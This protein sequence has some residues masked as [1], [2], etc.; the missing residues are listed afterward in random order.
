MNTPQKL[1]FGRRLLNLISLTIQHIAITIACG[2]CL[3]LVCIWFARLS[4]WLELVVHFSAHALFASF[5]VIPILWVTKHRRTAFVCSLVA[6]YFIFLVQ[7]WYLIPLP[8]SPKPD[9]LR[10]LSWNV[11]KA[12]EEFDSVVEVIRKSNPDVLV[13]IEVTPDLLERAPWITEQY[14][15]SKVLPSLTADTGS[16]IGIFCRNDEP[17]FSV[18]FEVRSFPWRKMPTIVAKLSSPDGTRHVDLVATHTYSPLP[19]SRATLRDTQIRKYLEWAAEQTNPQC[20]VGDLNTTPWTRSYW[21]LERA[22]FRDSRHGAGN[23]PSWPAWLGPLGIPID[24]AMT[25]GECKI[26][27]RKVLSTHAGSDHRPI[28]FKLSF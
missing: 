13:L 26:T 7:P 21:E 9:A 10:V 16:G 17:K 19:P 8:S 14:P 28:E 25:R 12:N 6:A 18:D 2:L 22:G 4:T 11:Y 3:T 24:H 15:N 5:V 20:L 23:C 1:S 27:E